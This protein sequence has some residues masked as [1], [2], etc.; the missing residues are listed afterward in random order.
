MLLNGY[1]RT[2]F[3]FIILTHDKLHLEVHLN[4]VAC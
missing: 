4:C 2:L 1:E 3:N